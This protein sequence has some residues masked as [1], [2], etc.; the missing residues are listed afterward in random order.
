M[1]YGLGIGFALRIVLPSCGGELN[2]RISWVARVQAGIR[3]FAQPQEHGQGA[4]V[5]AVI[6]DFKAMFEEEAA[7]VVGQVAKGDGGK[8]GS[9]SGGRVLTGHLLL[10]AS[11]L[12]S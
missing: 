3:D 4:I 2:G 5:L 1:G 6:V 8:D 12:N 11:G 7:R 9:R 10:K